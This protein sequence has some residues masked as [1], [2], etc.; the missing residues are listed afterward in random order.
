[1]RWRG[2]IFLANATLANQPLVGLQLVFARAND[3]VEDTE[4]T[5]MSEYQLYC[6]AQSGHCY[7]AALM[8]NLIGADWEPLS[9]DFFGKAVQR[10]AEYVPI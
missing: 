5:S 9:I 2:A 10:S 8:L 7:R 6:L 4:G 3:I 1:V